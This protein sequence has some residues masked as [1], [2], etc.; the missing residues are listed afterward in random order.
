MKMRVIS[1]EERQAI[2]CFYQQPTDSTIY[3]CLE[4]SAGIAYE[5]QPGAYVIIVDEYVYPS[6]NHATKEVAEKLMCFLGQSNTRY[7]IVPQTKEWEA[8]FINDLGFKPVV[9]YSFDHKKSQFQEELLKQYQQR[10]KE[11]YELKQVDESLW[12]RLFEYEFSS[13]FLANFSSKEEFLEKGLAYVILDG[14]E[15]AAAIASYTYYKDGY[16]VIIGT[17][18]PYR[19]QGL[20]TVLGA[21]FLLKAVKQ[22]KYPFWDAA[23]LTS[24]RIAEKMGYKGRFEYIS[25][26]SK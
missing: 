24:V 22:K 8:V 19:G 15:I 17:N 10:L 6:G 4:G 2:A 11:G 26:F 14:D 5:I 16:E 25:F 9:R 20:A 7:H 23:N 21:T 18:E 3:S 12:D 1:K 13:H